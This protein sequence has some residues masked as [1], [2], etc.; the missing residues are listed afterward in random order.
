V[1]GGLAAAALPQPGIGHLLC[2]I[3]CL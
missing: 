2:N 1:V 3:P